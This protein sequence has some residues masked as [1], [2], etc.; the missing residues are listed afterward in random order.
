MKKRQFAVIGLGT[1]GS[2]VA[3]ELASKNAQVLAID[4]VE[5]KVKDI[6]PYITQAVVA[7][8]TEEKVLRSLGIS[9]I[10]CAIVA[11]GQSMESS[12]MITLLL[13]ELGVKS[14]IVKSVSDLHSK[15]VA[16]LGADRVIFPEYEMA[17]K[18]AE[19]LVSPNILEEI[20]LSQE[21]NIVEMV[22]PKN[23]WGKSIR[24]SEIRAN[25]KVD[26]IAIKRHSPTITDEG[27]S[28]IK[29]EIAIA[30]GGEFEIRENDIM[31]L[32]GKETD[33]D[34]LKEI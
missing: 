13:K 32:V 33:L 15:I 30:P 3:R 11:I 6:T 14:I 5:E 8:A 16:K 10:D 12:I 22:A 24:E 1:F 18:L 34:H 20:E 17:K 31:V 25:F 2:S 7:D 4:T 28:D 27:Q 21:F 26:V 23:F 9:D 29:E 19:S